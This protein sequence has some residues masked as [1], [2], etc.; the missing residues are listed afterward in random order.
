[1]LTIIDMINISLYLDKPGK[2]VLF[3][4]ENFDYKI[5]E[6]DPLK[7]SNN[8]VG[9]PS[10]YCPSQIIERIDFVEVFDINLESRGGFIIDINRIK[11]HE[12]S[13]I[14]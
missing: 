9:H 3:D 2:V 5:Y 11:L 6:A 12:I 7:L 4:M 10:L 1:M 14:Y 8:Y 13:T